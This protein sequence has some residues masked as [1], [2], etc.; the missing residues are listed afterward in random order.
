MNKPKVFNYREYTELR[1]AYKA[2]LE[3]NN[4]LMADNKQLRHDKANLEIRCRI[5]KDHD[6]RMTKRVKELEGES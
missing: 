3:D 6:D 4:K 5:L 2:L 1:D